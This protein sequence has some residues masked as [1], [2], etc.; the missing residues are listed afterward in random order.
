MV[1]KT[2]KEAAAKQKA[3]FEAKKQAE[4]KARKK[5]ARELAKKKAAEEDALAT[6]KGA[7]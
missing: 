3:A 2:E 6:G 1:E 4:E 5:K 7:A